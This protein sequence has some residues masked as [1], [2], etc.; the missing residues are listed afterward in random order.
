MRLACVL[1]GMA[2]LAGTAQAA[3]WGGITPGA[4]TVEAVRARYGAPQRVAKQKMEGYDTQQ[5]IYEGAGAPA[6][7]KRMVVDFGYLAPS[8]F[9]PEV[10]RVFRLEPNPY[11]FTRNLVLD[12]WGR[13]TG[14]SE[15]DKPPSFFYTSGLVV[16]FD[17][18]GN[19]VSMVF[20]P[21]QP[22]PKDSGA[23]QP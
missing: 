16:Y 19:A 10:V 2:L 9:H 21:P 1:I 4:S 8:G 6:G 18:Q 13:P 15:P 11:I 23:K 3:D 14:M 20:T 5:W 7:M 17:E 22:T 12:G